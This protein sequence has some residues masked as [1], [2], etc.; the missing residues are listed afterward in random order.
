[1]TEFQL[2]RQL[3]SGRRLCPLVLFVFIEWD[4]PFGAVLLPEI[5]SV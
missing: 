3:W 1:M 4:L 5:P 2:K